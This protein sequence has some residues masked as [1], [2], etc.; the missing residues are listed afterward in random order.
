M[1]KGL[2]LTLM[3]VVVSVMGLNAMAMAPTVLEIRDII[4]GD[5]EDVSAS[6]IFVYPDALDLSEFVTDDGLP[7]DDL[8]WS[9]YESTDTYIINGMASLADTDDPTSPP[10]AKTINLADDETYVAVAENVTNS[11]DTNP[12][13]ITIRNNALSPIT[14]TAPYDEPSFTGMDA[15]TAL[16]MFCSDSDKA[17]SYTLFVFTNNEGFDGASGGPQWTPVVTRDFSAGTNSWAFE[18]LFGSS[19]ANSGTTGGICVSTPAAGDQA[20]RWMGPYGETADGGTSLVNNNVYRIRLTMNSTQTTVNQCP[21]WDFIIEN[22]NNNGSQG[23]FCYG[24]DYWF[25]D[26]LGG[27]NAIQGPSV[28]RSTFDIVWAPACVSLPAWQSAAF[29]TANEDANDMR[30]IFRMFDFASANYDAGNDSG[31]ICISEMKIDRAD[32]SS[33][34]S[35]AT[36]YSDDNLTAAN[37]RSVPA[38]SA[39]GTSSVFS[40]GNLTIEPTG[41]WTDEIIAIEPGDADFSATDLADNYPFSW[42]ANTL[43]KM[44]VVISSPDANSEAHPPDFIIMRMDTASNELFMESYVVPNMDRAAMPKQ[45][46]GTYVGFFYSHNVSLTSEAAY[47]TLRARLAVGALSGISA[48]TN[49]GGLTIESVTVKKVGL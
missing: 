48:F 39:S 16:T 22:Q 30:M 15:G 9:F 7:G 42:D 43:Y 38:V 34:T 46:G 26:N 27:A 44:E 40:G 25:L 32:I 13:T 17:G 37:W 31:T 4:V 2:T 45:A 11:R 19:G 49:D 33:L 47:K 35:S 18:K 1:R 41:T 24:A 12:E 23:A 21:L 28:G 14:G 29:S 10:A 20:A 6:N 36:V 8:F 5:A 3:A